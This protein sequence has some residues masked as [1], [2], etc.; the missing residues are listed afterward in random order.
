[1][2]DSP[3]R[4][5]F[6]LSKFTAMASLQTQ[7]GFAV[8]LASFINASKHATIQDM[9][10]VLAG[11]TDPALA[12]GTPQR[13]AASSSAQP[14]PNPGNASATPFH[15]AVSESNDFAGCVIDGSTIH[16]N[17]G[18]SVAIAAAPAQKSNKFVDSR[19]TNSNINHNSFN[20]DVGSHSRGPQQQIDVNALLFALLAAQQGGPGQGGGLPTMA[21]NF[22]SSRPP[23][24]K[25][26]KAKSTF[27]HEAR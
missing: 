22:Q 15:G 16:D 26:Q 5:S 9:A 27:F 17:S 10:L 24:R 25:A 13:S 8:D 12:A 7:T 3:P 1:V 20:G 11:P 2:E 14:S 21:N 18:N 19:I 4:L 6:L 23:R